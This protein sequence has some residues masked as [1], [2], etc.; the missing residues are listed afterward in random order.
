MADHQP[1]SAEALTNGTVSHPATK[2][3]AEIAAEHD[4][5]PKLIPHLDRHLIFPL[6]E[7]LSGEEIDDPEILKSKYELL[8]QTNMTDYVA[9]LWQKMN[10]SDEVPEEFRKKRRKSC[11]DYRSFRTKRP[12]SMS[13]SVTRA[14]LQTCEAI[15][16]P[17]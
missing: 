13:Y 2:T 10:D 17:I 1:P 11:R 12:R 8:K 9:T 7:F 14:S 4:L 15:K 5:L 6:L 16:S 3:A